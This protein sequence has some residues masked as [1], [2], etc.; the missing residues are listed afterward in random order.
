MIKT[1]YNLIEGAIILLLSR[2]LLIRFTQEIDQ[3]FNQEYTLKQTMILLVTR[4]RFSFH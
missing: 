4:D 3:F 1:L 2:L